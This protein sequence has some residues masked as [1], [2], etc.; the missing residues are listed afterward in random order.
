MYTLNWVPYTLYIH[1]NIYLQLQEEPKKKKKKR[2]QET[3]VNLISIKEIA[4]DEEEV[5]WRNKLVAIYHWKP[6]P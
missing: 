1:I 6:S 2:K 5:K 4:E 3:E